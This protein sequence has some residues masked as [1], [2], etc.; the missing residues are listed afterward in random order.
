MLRFKHSININYFDLQVLGNSGE[1]EE[2]DLFLP[3]MKN[4]KTAAGG[5]CESC[6]IQ[7]VQLVV[8]RV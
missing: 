7:R 1:E 8:V 4:G 2:D 6:F 5:I 3:F